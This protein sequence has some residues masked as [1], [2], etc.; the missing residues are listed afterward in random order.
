MSDE[1]NAFEKFRPIEID[2]LDKFIL[3]RLSN[4]VLIEIDE[5]EVKKTVGG[6]ITE[7]IESHAFAKNTLRRGKVVKAC[8]E[9]VPT[10]NESEF[11]MWQTDVQVKP[12]DIVYINHFDMRNSYYIS[13]GERLMKLVPYA[14]IICALRDG[15]ITMCNGYTLLEDVEETLYPGTLEIKRKIDDQGIV[16]Y[17]GEPNKRYYLPIMMHDH[18][19]FIEKGIAG[20]E[21]YGKCDGHLLVTDKRKSDPSSGSVKI[22]DRVMIGDLERVWY[23]EEWAYARFD[24]RKLYRVCQQRNIIAVLE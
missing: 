6:I 16:R 3:P 8:K 1:K 14:S 9:I 24:H 21:V 20:R 2:D 17:I 10:R 23:L 11:I 7:G 13:Q 12:G 22:G 18:S 4:K 19:K 5:S 15:E